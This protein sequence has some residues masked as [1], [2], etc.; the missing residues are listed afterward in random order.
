MSLL[1]LFQALT[2]PPPPLPPS[3]GQGK[4]AAFVVAGI[5]GKGSMGPVVFVGSNVG[6]PGSIDLSVNGVLDLGI[7]GGRSL[8]IQGFG[9]TGK[10]SVVVVT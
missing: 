4:S 3:P 1:L 5:I 9:W 6:S 7:G 10:S 2:G 8:A